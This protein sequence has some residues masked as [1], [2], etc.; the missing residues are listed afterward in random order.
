MCGPAFCNADFSRTRNAALTENAS[1][2]LRAEFFNVCNI[3]DLGNSNKNGNDAARFGRI[4]ATRG[5][6]RVIQ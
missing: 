2:Q 1:L 5:L 3:V 4:F 6:P